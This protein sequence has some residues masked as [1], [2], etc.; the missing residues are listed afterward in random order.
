MNK[1]NDLFNSL[2]KQ[3]E[4]Q[5]QSDFGSAIGEKLQQ[6]LDVRK[7]KVTSDVF[8]KTQAVKEEVEVIDE[9]KADI[10]KLLKGGNTKIPSSKIDSILGDLYDDS[11]ATKALVRNKVYQQG[12]DN[13]KKKN[14]YKKDTADFALYQLGQ[15]VQQT[16]G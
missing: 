4:T 12:E 6:A 2:V 8:N 11:K 7:I 3:D 10:N 15:Q 1:I 16:R 5:A 9:S 14:P 13:P